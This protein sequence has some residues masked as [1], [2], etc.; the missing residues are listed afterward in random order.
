MVSLTDILSF[1]PEVS[2]SK[3]VRIYADGDLDGMVATGL[4]W[5]SLEQLGLSLDAYFP[6]PRNLQG[7]EVKDAISIELPLSKGVTF[8]GTV[9]LLDHHGP[10][11]QHIQVFKGNETIDAWMVSDRPIRAVTDVVRHLCPEDLPPLAERLIEAVA[12]IDQGSPAT[13]LAQ[14]MHYAYRFQIADPEMRSMIPAWVRRGQ[15]DEFHEWAMRGLKLQSMVRERAELL[16]SSSRPLAESAGSP[17]HRVVWFVYDPQD[18]ISA[19]AMRETMFRLEDEFPV[20]VALSKHTTDDT[21]APL[22][23]RG[24]SVG[25]KNS[26]VDLQPVFAAAQEASVIASAG[27]RRNVGGIQTADPIPLTTMLEV[28]QQ[29]FSTHAQEI[30]LTIAEADTTTTHDLLKS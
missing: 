19:A 17:A 9:I 11:P 29:V 5:R 2:E 21:S 15:W 8:S 26:T 14:G 20:V 23:I 22:L 1:L 16:V 30:G 7:L 24:A 13:P 4:L 3:T 25:T 12:Q 6:P 27:G 10:D 18:T 28:L